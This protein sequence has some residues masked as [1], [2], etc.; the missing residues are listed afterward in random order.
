MRLTS[1]RTSAAVRCPAAA[2]PGSSRCC[3]SAHSA[4]P[5]AG[6]PPHTWCMPPSPCLES[7]NDKG[8]KLREQEGGEFQVRRLQRGELRG[9]WEWRGLTCAGGTGPVAGLAG[10]AVAI[11]V[12]A[13]AASQLASA[14]LKTGGG[15]EWGIQEGRQKKR[16]SHYRKGQANSHTGANNSNLEEVARKR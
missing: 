5:L 1:C 9:M 16:C 12:I 11:V 3:R 6:S 14:S 13:R 4:S 15:G 2:L 10:P 7:P 8:E